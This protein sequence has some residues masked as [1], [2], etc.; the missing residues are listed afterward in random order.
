MFQEEAICVIDS[1]W[2][3]TFQDGIFYHGWGPDSTTQLETGYILL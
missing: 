3:G 1:F 2:A